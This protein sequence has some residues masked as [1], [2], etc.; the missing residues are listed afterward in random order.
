MTIQYIFDILFKDNNVFMQF[1]KMNER[2]EKKKKN[3][4]FDLI[5]NFIFYN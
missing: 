2:C 1:N 5:N 3:C 4:I